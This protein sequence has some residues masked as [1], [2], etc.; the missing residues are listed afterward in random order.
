M[1]QDSFNVLQDASQ[2]P[3]DGSKTLQRRFQDASKTG[4]HVLQVV[5]VAD[6][7]CSV[8]NS[9]FLKDVWDEISVLQVRRTP[10]RLFGTPSKRPLRRLWM[11]PRRFEGVLCKQEWLANLL[12]L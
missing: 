12:F 8:R 9:T 10:P 6:R 5:H 11:P 7:E 2:A 4:R 3:Q 1:L